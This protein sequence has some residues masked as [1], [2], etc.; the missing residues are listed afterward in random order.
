MNTVLEALVYLSALLSLVPFVRTE[1]RALATLFWFPRLLAGALS[2]VLGL[3]GATG[4]VVGLLRRDW[5]LA[6]AGTLGA[7]LSARYLR[8]IP[9]PC[10]E[11]DS[12]LGPAGPAQPPLP[13]TAHGD[14][15]FQRDLVYGRNPESGKPLLADL[16]QPPD[17][18]PRSGL[19]ILYVHGGAWRIGSKDMQTRTFFRRLT[20]Q[21]HVI[22]DIAYTLWPEAGLHTMVVE[23]KQA[24]LWLKANAAAYG[25]DPERIVLM[26]GS[27]GAHL[28]LLAAYTPNHPAFQPARKAGDT[29]VHS[30]VAFY[31]PVDFLDTSFQGG[32]DAPAAHG[33]LD[34]VGRGMMKRLFSLD[35]EDVE[36]KV[37]RHVGFDDFM[38]ALL[39]GSPDEI[40]DTYRLLSPIYHVGDHCPPTLLVHGSDDVFGLTPGVHRLHRALQEVDV[41]VVL[42]E[43]PHTDH[44]FDLILPQISPVAMAATRDVIRFLARLV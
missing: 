23:V 21:G 40:P 31:P 6:A 13:A 9:A 37:G 14:V 12:A 38:T 19:G 35:A 5:K 27:A 16:W 34:R 26:G 11:L 1:D 43:F 41:P 25:V 36:D 8:D 10:G 39:G 22:L 44:G 18:A 30:V 17:G 33:G 4:A 2:P 20:A 29:A 15:R 32:Q 42:V 7:V 24:I 3:T 28:A